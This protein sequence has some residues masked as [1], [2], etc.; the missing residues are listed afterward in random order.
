MGSSIWYYP[1]DSYGVPSTT[2]SVLYDVDSNA[3]QSALTI[4]TLYRWSVRVR[5]ANG[6]TASQVVTYQP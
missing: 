4:G 1:E 2:L 6:N 3:S 5:D